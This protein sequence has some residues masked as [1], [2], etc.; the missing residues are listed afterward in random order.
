MKVHIRSMVDASQPKQHGMSAGIRTE[1]IFG[2]SS[3]N[4][5]GSGICMIMSRYNFGSRFGVH[6]HRL[7]FILSK[8][9]WY[10]RM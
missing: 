6:M 1:V 2:T 8:T 10:G 9:R 5:N 4:C 7:G 3:Q